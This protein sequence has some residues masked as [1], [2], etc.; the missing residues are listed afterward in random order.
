MI[1]NEVNTE[2]IMNG[3]FISAVG[4]G[5]VFIA[6]VMLFYTFRYIPNILNIKLK[7]K[8]KTKKGKGTE[9]VETVVTGEVNAAITAAIHLF[10]DETHD[11]ESTVV[12]IKRIS[13]NYSPWSSKIYS[14]RNF[15]K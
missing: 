12:T 8:T 3:L 13:R 2:V 7:V 10:F 15:K 6:L 11:A 4:Y 9:E 5:V 1:I 14:M